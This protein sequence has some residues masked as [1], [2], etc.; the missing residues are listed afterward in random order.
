MMKYNAI[1]IGAGSIGGLKPNAFDHPGSKNIITH[2]HAFYNNNQTKLTTIVDKN[3]KKAKEAAERWS[4]NF[5]NKITDLIGRKNDIVSVCTPTETH[6]EVL[7]EVVNF[8]KPKIVIAEK[9][10]CKNTKSAKHIIDMYAAKKI[11]LIINY[12]RRFLPSFKEI[13]QIFNLDKIICYSATFYYTR[14]LSHEG[15]HAIDLCNFLF[16]NFI[17]CQRLGG[18]VA[19]RDKNDPN[20]HA[21]LKFQKCPFVFLTGGDGK[22]YKAFQLEVFTNIGKIVFSYHGTYIDFYGRKK[23]AVWGNFEVLSSNLSKRFETDLNNSLKYTIEEAVRI[24]DSKEYF[25]PMKYTYNAIMVHEII[26]K[27]KGSK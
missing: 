13:K 26:D 1:V 18:G 5:D 24:T 3:I 21:I 4:C 2:A 16:G 10:F 15:S 17:D 12:P 19:D 11:P 20:I 7:Y 8:L 6:H 27:L 23:E 9:P 25:D 14:G 22:H